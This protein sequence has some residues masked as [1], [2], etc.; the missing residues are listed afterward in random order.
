[1]GSH[2]IFESDFDCLTEKMKPAKSLYLGFYFLGIAT[3]LPWNFFITPFAYWMTKLQRTD[4]KQTR[5]MVEHYSELSTASLNISSSVVDFFN[6]TSKSENYTEDCG[7]SQFEFN[8]LQKF[9][10]SLLGVTAKGTT[11]AFCFLTTILSRKISRDKRIVGCL[12]GYL[13]CLTITSA[14]VEIDFNERIDLFFGLTL[15]IFL[16]MTICCAI[17]QISILG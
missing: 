1:M 15:S 2:P 8:N 11:F 13:V 17:L 5:A 10:N 14:M 6:E 4:W 9:W 12:F 16:L 3:L 7:Q